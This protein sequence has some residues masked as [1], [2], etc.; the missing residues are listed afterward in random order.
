MAARKT[1][2]AGSKPDKILRDA[3]M[4]EL[5]TD[6]K[7]NDGRTVKKFRRIA[8]NLVTSGLDNKM[9]AIKEIWD[10]VEGRPAQSIAVGQDPDLEPIEHV[11]RPPMTRE[12]WLKT[13]SK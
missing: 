5:N 4:L 3:L 8:A 1:P 10:R 2:S 6:T 13:H 12:E 11:V 9:D 7:D